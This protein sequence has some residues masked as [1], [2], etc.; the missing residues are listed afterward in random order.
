MIT[1]YPPPRPNA[2][3]TTTVVDTRLVQCGSLPSH[4]A[5]KFSNP[6]YNTPIVASSSAYFDHG[7]YMIQWNST[8]RT[9]AAVCAYLMTSSL[10]NGM[11]QN[12]WQNSAACQIG[13]LLFFQAQRISN[14]CSV[15]TPSVLLF[16]LLVP[17]PPYPYLLIFSPCHCLSSQQSLLTTMQDPCFCCFSDILHVRSSLQSETTQ[18]KLFMVLIPPLVQE[19]NLRNTRILPKL[20]T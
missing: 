6:P 1:F 8:L 16:P 18:E 19:D 11:Q 5:A 3:A 20:C 4:P 12:L 17:V 13:S 15:F 14:A 2:P 10:K 9:S 7:K